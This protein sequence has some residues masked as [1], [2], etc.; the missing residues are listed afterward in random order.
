VN[1]LNLIAKC[2]SQRNS[3]KLRR[4]SRT[5]APPIISQNADRLKLQW[6]ALKEK[7]VNPKFNWYRINGVSTREHLLPL[8]REMTASHCSFCDGFPLE[9]HSNE[10][11]EHFRPKSKFPELAFTW[12]NLYYCCE[13]CQ[14]T[15]LEKW[16]ESLIA[17]DENGYDFFHFFEFD[18]T[19]GAIR[20]NSLA[21]ELTKCRAQVTINLYGLD[22]PTRRKYRMLEFRKW[23][24]MPDG[25]RQLND[26]AY[27]DFLF[28]DVPP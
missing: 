11:I 2:H 20:P 26:F 1:Y 12:E 4:F 16:D 17:P 14:S 7:S 9:G 18:W 24:L 25:Q 19:N 15:K 21:N 22:T 5:D 23:N 6:L 27:R 8:L 3:V 28:P 13:K 10:P